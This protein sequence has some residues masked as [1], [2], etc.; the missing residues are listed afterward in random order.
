MT[1]TTSLIVAVARNGVIG[2]QGKLP[3]RVSSDLKTFR[4]LTMGKP[5][6]MGRKTFQSIG[7]PLDGRDNIVV[8]RDPGF[9]VE[10]VSIFPSIA[11]ALVLARA[12]ARTN[13]TDEVMVIGGADIFAATV[14]EAQRVYWTEIDGE[15]DG[16]VFF[17]ALDPGVWQEVS[18]EPL[19]RGPKDEYDAVLKIYERRVS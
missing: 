13:G 17:P 3:W 9:E 5:I 1:V 19:P 16:D 10:G 14:G 8:T 12:L 11:E 2:R 15:P 7:R 4:R 6:V 18:A